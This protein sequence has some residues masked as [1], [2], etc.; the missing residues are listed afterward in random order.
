MKLQAPRLEPPQAPMNEED[1]LLFLPFAPEEGFCDA[2]LSGVQQPALEL[3]GVSWKNCTL[4]RCKLSGAGCKGSTFTDVVF[5]G[6]DLSNGDFSD[7]VFTRVQFR[8]CKLTGANFFACGL[9][10][11][12]FADS[13]CDY[14]TFTEGRA[15]AL[16]F[17]EC[18]LTHARLDSLTGK[19][20][21]FTGCNLQLV[22][23]RETLLR[24]VDLTD[25]LL[26][27]GSYSAKELTGAKVTP[28]QACDLARL[29]GV[30]VVD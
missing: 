12:A 6:C 23:F 11:V 3:E 22:D 8:G 2:A 10:D 19:D 13:L 9:H 28:L 24:G 5:S 16:W 26:G 4:T 17:T 25:C 7:C 18:N 20:Y 27:G 15:R 14:T 30:I 29:L 1:F 21:G